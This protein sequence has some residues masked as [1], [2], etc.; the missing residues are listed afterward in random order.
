MV[1]IWRHQKHDHA[2]H[3]Q[4]APNF[5]TACKTIQR[6]SV[7]NFTLLDQSNRVMG[8]RSWRIFYYVIWE[9]GLEG[10]GGILLPVMAATI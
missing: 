4:F 7:P 9:H 5:D 6:V 8:K 2:N 10:G 1:Y 3:D